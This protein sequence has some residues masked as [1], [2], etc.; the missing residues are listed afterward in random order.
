MLL[1]LH[2]SFIGYAQQDCKAVFTGQILDELNRPVTGA[3]ILLM[4]QQKGKASDGEGGFSFENLCPGSYRVKVQ[5]LGY[6]D[7]ELTVSISGLVNKVIR[8]EEAVTELGEVIVQHHDE[9]QTEHASNYVKLDERQLAETAGKSLGESLK[10]VPGVN[11]I[12]TG[13]GIFKPVIHGVHSQRVLILNHGLRQEGQQ[14]GAEHA[15]EIDPFIASTIVV[16]KDAS[17]IKY[18]TDA[19]GGVI[20]VNPPEL[21]DESPLGG[22]FNTVL[23]S[24]GRSATISGMLE[25]GVGKYNGWGWRVQ[26]TAKQTGDFNTPDYSLTNTGIRELNFSAAT[27]YHTQEAGFDIFFSHF[28]TDL[29]ILKGT[30]IGNLDD[31]VTAMERDEPQYT[32]DFSYKITE[33][34]QEVSHNLLKLNGHIKGKAGEW[35]F[36]YGFQNNNRKEFDIRIGDLSRIPAIDLQ[37]NTHSLETEWETPHTDKRTISIGINA[38]HQSNKNVYGTQRIPFIPNFNNI[39]GGLFAI[40]KLFLNTWTVD[41]GT[42]YDYRHYAVKGYDFK[43]TLYNTSFSFNNIS[44]ALGAT[45]QISENQTLNLNLSSAWRPPH[46]AELYSLGTHQSAAAIEYGLLLNDSTNEVMHIK[47]VNFN[48]EQA[49]KFVTGYQYRRPNVTVDLTGYANYIFNYIYLRPKGITTNVRGVYPY[50]RY[51]Q[52]DALF[53]GADLTMTW[54]VERHVK[55]VPKISLLRASDESN[56]DY[57]IFI[58]SNNYELVVRYERPWFSFLKNFYVESKAKYVAKQTRAPRVITVRE[59]KEGQEQGI[60]PFN[61]GS[62]NFDFMASP[63]GYWLWNLS[64]GFSIK[65]RKLQYDF[66]IAS[67]NTLDQKYREY[68]NRFRYYAD[69]PGRNIIF[70]FKCIF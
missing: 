12:Q 39:S 41:I 20:V 57:L 63:S 48:T 47:D 69:D 24:N 16:I 17:A 59:I 35:R 29:G 50:F 58:P 19:L 62:P 67:E 70:S 40:T 66:R 14:W 21:P 65:S 8:L 26:G 55:V 42:R 33:P 6:K 4:P 51:T 30:S 44:V 13:P 3:A 9:T 32:A 7:V 45:N 64:A 60:D 28:Q 68:T 25:G 38:M 11:S 52:T 56:H 10:Q 18:G 53:L 1:L 34:R 37:L 2:A 5:Y 43:N 31:L 36:Q 15:P 54:Q 23:Q 61:N 27:G 46:V 49:I 22:T